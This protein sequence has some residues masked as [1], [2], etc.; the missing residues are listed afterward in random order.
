MSL[1]PHL[2][3]SA[4]NGTVINTYGNKLLSIDIGLRRNFTF[5]F[6]L[7]SVDRPIIGADFISSFDLLVDLKRRRLI[8]S[9]TG[10]SVNAMTARV[11]TPTPTHFSI[12]NDYGTIL[13]MFPSLTAPPN[14][15][16]PVKHNV[17]HHIVTNGRLPFSQPRRLDALKHKAA[18]LEFEY[19]TKLGICQP[20][21]SP[22]SS[23]LHMVKKKD[24]EDWR[25]C[26]DYRR[27]NA[28]TVPDRYPIPHIQSFSMHLQGCTIFS[29][30]DL[31]RAYHIIPVAIED[32]PKTA[33]TTPFGL[34]EFLRMP[35]GLRNA[36]QT[37]Q[38]FMNEVVKDLDFPVFVYIDDI[39]VAS[40]N[41]EEHKQHLKLLFQKLSEFDIKIKSSKCI[42]GVTAL[43]FLSHRITSN[44]IAP[45]PERVSIINKF[46]TP[47][48][49]TQIQQFV[50]MVN[51]YYRFIPNL[52]EL[53]SPVHAHM[54]TLTNS[55]GKASN[56][57]PFT[58]P[59]ICNDAFAKV[60]VALANV[61]L[62]AHPLNEGKFSITTDASNTAV[63]AVLQQYNN[64]CW[65]PLAFFSKKL[66][67]TEIKYSA[68]DRE[69][70]A[71]YLALKHFRYFVE[72]RSFT[73]Y[74]DHKPL[75]TALF[76]KTER[77]PRQTNH[78]SYIS[79]FT[80]DIQHING[81]DNVVADCLSRV[82]DHELAVLEP[83]GIDLNKLAQAQRTDNELEKL[84]N[85]SQL[86]SSKFKLELYEFPNLT[87]YCETS[88]GKNRPYVP[89][90]MR[91]IVFENFHRITHPGVRATRKL[92]STRYFWP[93]LN[94]HVTQWT[95]SC[96]SCQKS[97]IHRHTRSEPGSFPIPNGRFEHIHMDIVGPLP[98]SN[99]FQYILTIVDRF[100]RW[101]EAYPIS[102]MTATTIA[103]TF[104]EQYISRFGIPLKLTTDR[105]SQF[106]S[107]L[108]TELTKLLGTHRI[109]TTAY[110][111]QADGMVERF[112]RTFK[113][114]LIARGDTIHWSAELPI[115]LLGLRASF[116]EDL[117]C[118]PADLVYG[119][120]LRLPGEFFESTSSN[121]TMDYNTFLEQL[122]T[123]MRN[124]I[125]VD[126]RKSTQP[127]FVPK[128]I[129][130]CE[131]VFI[132]VDKIRPALTPPYEGP[133]KVIRRTRKNFVVDVN[134]KQTTVAIDRVKPAFGI[135]A[136]GCLSEPKI[137]KRVHFS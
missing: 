66:S 87:L 60:K 5:S 24:N 48:S 28:I 122:R 86:Q 52:A 108:F 99:G 27:L 110:H 128:D 126:T 45:S 64:K 72:G 93:N 26:G 73:I 134:G 58:W 20:S 79:Q 25:P 59:E 96:V 42:F 32:V 56:K 81:K 111:P 113:A 14:Y 29:K 40:K 62:L 47:T 16:T 95:K 116:K 8:D 69:L 9:Q 100:T 15:N 54:A 103:K 33:I 49:V 12:D 7:A 57:I 53:L 112:H 63:G 80:N 35:F 91:R 61:T 44:G 132:R 23:A 6:V 106:E 98:P 70:L 41:E 17:V 109:R 30:I 65:E 102:N 71:I 18:K 121:Y 13:K 89:E 19:M 39:L 82:S 75:T 10:L 127:I 115:V 130:N 92:I 38:R 123:T 125:P 11:D 21:S 67:S 133:F 84:L 85:T 135:L 97:K 114:S 78:L 120:S 77:S 76:T 74:T 104:V 46:P 1:D 2:S 4:A 43:D 36:A 129:E 90:S 22:S 131:F 118:T 101:P 119:Q 117:K 105:G 107:K 34:F 83:V 68:F 94:K 3:L 136:V 51:F 50:G 124:L 88:T 31:V 37:F 55:K 137:V